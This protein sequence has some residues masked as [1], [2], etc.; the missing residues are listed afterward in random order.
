MHSLTNTEFKQ[1]K[2]EQ[3]HSV[4]ASDA[5]T[6]CVLCRS[7][8]NGKQYRCGSTVVT[9]CDP[10]KAKSDAENTR[11]EQA[12]E[13]RRIKYIRERAT[14]DEFHGGFQHVP[15]ASWK[16][17]DAS[18]AEFRSKVAKQFQAFAIT[19][20]ADCSAV[21]AGTTGAGK[22]SSVIAALRRLRNQAEAD[23]IATPGLQATEHPMLNMLAGMWWF[24]GSELASARRQH[25]M[26]QGVSPIVKN[27]KGAALLIIDELGYEDFSPELSEVIHLRESQRR[28]TIVTTGLTPAAF[29]TRYGDA[30][31]R[32]LTTDGLVIEG[33]GS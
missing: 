27:A 16:F 30:T 25:P 17:Y 8:G 23:A 29:R 21:L 10:C 18:A 12:A 24:T 14:R 5:P 6:D 22:T 3:S 31:W 7:P 2:S 9:L 13:A 19:Y 15:I 32:K 33:F 28:P 1:A 26:G 11:I 20:G 4:S